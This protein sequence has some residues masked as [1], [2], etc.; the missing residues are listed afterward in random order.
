MPR[1]L[2]RCKLRLG[3]YFFYVRLPGSVWCLHFFG[4]VVLLRTGGLGVSRA[5]VRFLH[6]SQCLSITWG[7]M[8]G[9]LF[10]NLRSPT[11]TVHRIVV[12]RRF[13]GCCSEFV[14]V[15]NLINSMVFWFFSQ[16]D[17]L[18]QRVSLFYF[19]ITAFTFKGLAG[20]L[21]AGEDLSVIFFLQFFMSC[22][23]YHYHSFH[24]YCFCYIRPSV[25]PS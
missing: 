4:F 6:F 23:F 20:L 8:P 7:Q 19:F 1:F 15:F 10:P 13:G 2:R 14:F 24:Q 22:S 3:L 17:C 5:S 12:L 18:F 9:I 25:L 11:C 16:W 21:E